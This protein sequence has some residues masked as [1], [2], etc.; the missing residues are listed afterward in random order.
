MCIRDRF[1]SETTSAVASTFM[2][3]IASEVPNKAIL[4]AC[5]AKVVMSALSEVDNQVFSK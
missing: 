3:A 2:S 5:A 4:D 1:K